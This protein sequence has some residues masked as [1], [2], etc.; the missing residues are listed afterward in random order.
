MLENRTA[1]EPRDTNLVLSV[2]VIHERVTLRDWAL[3]D[4]CWPVGIAG[5]SL[6]KSVPVLQIAERLEL[7]A[8]LE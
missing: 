8:L 4:E 1:A 3:G 5:A 7:P 6:E 2:P